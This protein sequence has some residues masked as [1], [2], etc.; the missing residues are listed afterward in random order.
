[1]LPRSKHEGYGK[2]G[3]WSLFFFFFAL[4]KQVCVK[5]IQIPSAGL[6]LF[7]IFQRR[8]KSVGDVCVAVCDEKKIAARACMRASFLIAQMEIMLLSGACLLRIIHQQDS[9]ASAAVM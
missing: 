5:C 9:G 7:D 4:R 1:M 6:K 2:S 3:L 8:A